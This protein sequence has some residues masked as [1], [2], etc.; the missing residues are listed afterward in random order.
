M[1]S[2]RTGTLFAGTALA[3]ALVTALSG[4]TAT[5][6]TSPDSLTAPGSTFAGAAATSTGTATGATTGTGAPGATAATIADSLTAPG[7]ATLGGTTAGP[8][9]SLAGPVDSTLG[10]TAAG[11]N[12]GTNSGTTAAGASGTNAGTESGTNSGTESSANSGTESGANPGANSGTNSGSATATTGAD[13]LARPGD[14]AALVDP[15]IGTGSGGAVVGAV[16][17]FPGASAPFGM[18]QF[19]PDTPSRPSGGRYA[20]SDNQI[21]GFS[22]THL[23]GVGCPITGDIP[24][25]PAVGAVPADPS[26]TSEPFAHTD[27]QASPGRYSV[28]LGAAGSRIQANLSA[29][30]RTGV[31]QLTYPRTTQAQ[32]L[33]KVAG[34]QNGSSGATFHTIGDDEIAGS[35]TSGHFCGQPDSYTVYFTAKFDR[36]FTA[37][38]TW[39]GTTAAVRAGSTSMAARGGQSPAREPLTSKDTSG[40][41]VVAGGYVTFDASKNP[42]VGFRVALSFV[43]EAGARANLAEGN[44]NFDVN[45]QAAATRAAWNQQLRKIDIHGGTPAEQ[46]T[47]YTALYHSLLHPSLFSDTDGRYIGFDSKIH[48]LPRGHAQY[49]DFSG[50]DIYRSQIPLLAVLDPDVTSD[51]AASLLRDGDQ[52][53]WLP[54]WPVANGE[55]GVMNGDAADPILAGAF[56]FG[57]TGFDARHAVAEMVHGAEGTGA[58]GQ[59]WYQER[60]SGPAY[61]AK[62]FVPNTQADSISP[63]P[64]GASETLEYTVA[65]FA[66]SQLAAATGQRSV[67]DRFA[68]RSQNWS[69]LF[70]T[71]T[72][73]IRPRDAN[74]AFPAGD[75]LAMGGGFGQTGFQ[76][77]NAAQ[78]TWMVPQNLAALINGMGGNATARARLDQFFTQLN[79]GPNAP[80]DWQ[81]NE[82][83]FDVPWAYDSAGAPWRTQATV[84]QVMSQLYQPIPG[85]E[86]GN[87]DLGAMSS[88]YVWAAMGLYPQTP[89]VPMLVVGTPLFD[90]TSI[91]AGHGRRIE[92]S[93]PGAGDARPYVQGLRINGHATTHT[94]LML[95]DRPGV[96]RLDFAVGEQP[97]EGWGVGA[98]DAPPSFGAGPVA[99]PPTTRAQLR[100][101]PAQL[102]LSAGGQAG[103]HVLVDN[104]LGA[105]PATVTWTATAPTP[106]IGFTPGGATVTAAAGATVSVPLTV[107]ADSQAQS[108]FY[109]VA[110]AGRASNGAVIATAQVLVT[111]AKP[112]ELIPTAYVSNFSDNTVTPVDRRTGTAGPTIPVGSGPDGVVVTPDGTQVFVANN[113]SN[114]VTVIDTSDNHVITTVPVGSVA[115]DVAVTPDG[116]TVW[117]SNFG[118]GTVQSIDVATHT[119]GT[120]VKVG[121]NPQRMRIAPDGKDLWVPN[122][123]DGTVSEIDVTSRTVVRTVTVGA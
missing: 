46:R 11:A 108:G 111:V 47:F 122:Q 58:P 115:A 103:V 105:Q 78:Y 8:V 49:A 109:E 25:L 27:E 55:S 68:G 104:S 14:P 45:Q 74:G 12:S 33:V 13:S 88:W 101:D 97:N 6:A 40:S 82:P 19:S 16:D 59:G 75:P 42:T 64:N 90:R 35:V 83:N 1:S 29:S 77:G 107:T 76:E 7:S 120:P 112:G 80:F 52:M 87:D 110:I 39:G 86:P 63:V 56:A 37:T 10:R 99:F 50:W 54:K 48:T 32:L 96:T 85:G 28:G 98:G 2:R 31:A 69:N 81:G 70:D 18:V 100:V 22:L 34:S 72:G 3:T 60:P 89:G 43:S 38:G 91:D 62:G 36:S 17:T 21:T 15:F 26:S 71:A 93:A 53:G 117:V 65:D 79:A 73:Y 92:I 44:V 113:N 57:A 30:A 67:A 94:W 116:K 84:R 9:D 51:L 114:N 123:G 20:Y 66:I 4:L 106:G 61:L 24:M 41:G 121:G 95:A 5:A 119:A 118:D 23:S 102:R